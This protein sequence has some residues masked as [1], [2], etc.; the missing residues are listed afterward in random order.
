MLC[1]T[2]NEMKVVT[3]YEVLETK[4]LNLIEIEGIQSILNNTY[5]EWYDNID[6]IYQET[7]L[8]PSDRLKIRQG[9]VNRIGMVNGKVVF[10][11]NVLKLKLNDQG[12]CWEEFITGET[13]MYWA[14]VYGGV[15]ELTEIGE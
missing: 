7:C 14:D 10:E 5:P 3:K 12:D 2:E 6:C 13:I 15:F 1:A 4:E 11:I 9:E 8:Q